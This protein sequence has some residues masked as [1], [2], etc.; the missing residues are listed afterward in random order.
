MTEPQTSPSGGWKCP[1]SH[2]RSQLGRQSYRRDTLDRIKA[3]F[4]FVRTA[5]SCARRNANIVRSPPEIG[6]YSIL[7]SS[8]PPGGASTNSRP[9]GLKHWRAKEQLNNEDVNQATGKPS[10]ASTRLTKSRRDSPSTVARDCYETAVCTVLSIVVP[11]KLPEHHEKLKKKSYR[12][13]K[14]MD[15]AIQGQARRKTC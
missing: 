15:K 14:T 13:R 10:R 9:R 6:T 4:S 7:R 2:H 3:G 11:A 1:E 12:Q 5:S 8:L